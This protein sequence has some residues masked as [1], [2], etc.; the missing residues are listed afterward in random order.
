[1]INAAQNEAQQII[2]AAR[3]QAEELKKNTE[4]EVKLFA[5]QA[6]EAL[7]SEI[8]DLITGDVV[9]SNVK[10]AFADPDFMKKVILVIA[11]DW[12]KKEALVIETGEQC[13]RHSQ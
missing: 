12:A 8:T 10:A 7:K 4:A 13:K 9:S 5:S 6:V 2:A 1:M 3:K 11:Q